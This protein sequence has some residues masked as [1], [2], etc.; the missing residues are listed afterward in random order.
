MDVRHR[1]ELSP[2]GL[3]YRQ[4]DDWI[5]FIISRPKAQFSHVE[6]LVAVYIAETINPEAREWVT[7]QER[8]ADDLEVG[9]RIVKS[10][11]AKLKQAGLLTTRRRRIL[12]SKNAFN[13]YAIVAVEHAIPTSYVHGG[14]RL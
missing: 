1:K 13:S 2:A 10:A 3:F 8:I 5:K 6:K 14:A 11:V 12:A 7:S 4:R 9:V